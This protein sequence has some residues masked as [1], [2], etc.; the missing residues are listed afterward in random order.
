MRTSQVLEESHPHALPQKKIY[1][2]IETLAKTYLSASRL[3]DGKSDLH[4][5]SLEILV[6]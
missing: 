1:V 5:A 3:S 6:A 2:L 4:S